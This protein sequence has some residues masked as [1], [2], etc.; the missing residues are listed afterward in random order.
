VTDLATLR[1]MNEGKNAKAL[2][3]PFSLGNAT[4]LPHSWAI[5]DGSFLRLQ[6]V[7][8]GYTLPGYLSRKIACKQLR[9]Y[10]TV[11]NLWTWTNYTG[12]DPEV[13]SPVRGSSTSGLTPGVDYSSYP[14][15]LSW[16]FGL[17][18]KF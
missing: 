17:N 11:N 1:Q 14:K 6:N 5:E 18:V 3:S 16:T 7:T 8:L 10:C 15:S 9:V 2:W 12:Y 13:S 4:V